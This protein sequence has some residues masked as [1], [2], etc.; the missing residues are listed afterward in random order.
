M[1]YHA[2]QISDIKILEPRISNHGQPLIYF[3]L[4]RENVLVYLS[5]A[6]EKFCK[7]TGFVNN[8]IWTKWGSYGFEK[9]GIL[10][11]EEYYPNALSETYKGVSGY[12]YYA[13][14]LELNKNNIGINN[15]VTTSKPVMINGF[16]VISDAYMEIVKAAAKGEIK[17]LK[18]EDHSA[19]KLNWIKNTIFNEYNNPDIK[20]DYKYFIENKFPFVQE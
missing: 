17:L 3:S 12:I 13:E 4:K 11:L 20:S 8:G 14:N 7:E 18:Y 19:D 5:N 9:S 2:S 16:E 15:V 10:V 1:Y 6:I